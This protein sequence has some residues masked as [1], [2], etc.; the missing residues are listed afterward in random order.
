MVSLVDAD[1]AA[2]KPRRRL[3]PCGSAARE[4]AGSAAATQ[5]G[6][7]AMHAEQ[8]GIYDQAYSTALV[9]GGAQTSPSADGVLVSTDSKESGLWLWQ[10]EAPPLP[11]PKFR[12]RQ[13]F[14]RIV[15]AV[16]WAGWIT[17]PAGLAI[18]VFAASMMRHPDRPVSVAAPAIAPSS[19][20]PAVVAPPSVVVP[21]AEPAAAQLEP[22]PVPTTP[23]A[24]IPAQ[25][26]KS[27]AQRKSSRTAKLARA[28]HVRRGSP[29]PMPGVLTPPLT[30]H[31]GG[32]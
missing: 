14:R 20:P 13:I 24:K 3:A 5:R 27:S 6:L 21:L 32:Y 18:A 25:T 19:A 4:C 11:R 22:V 2:S 15:S 26:V 23:T 30:W 10:G 29:V 7:C 8:E 1:R 31:G 16:G 17:L 12:D 28:S 9:A